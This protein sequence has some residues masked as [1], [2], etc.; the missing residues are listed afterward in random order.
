M[1]T[2][3]KC[4]L[5]KDISEYSWSIRGIKRHSYAS[6]MLKNTSVKDVQMILGH[7]QASTTLDIY[8]HVLPGYNRE[9]AKKVEGMFT[10]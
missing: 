2:C 8:G 6:W 4:R 7:A 3:T 10:D 9:A 1:K 5:P